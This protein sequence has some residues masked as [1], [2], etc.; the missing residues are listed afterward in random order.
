MAT[1]IQLIY[2]DIETGRIGRIAD[3]S[4]IITPAEM[5]VFTW[6]TVLFRNVPSHAILNPTS[7]ELTINGIFKRSVSELTDDSKMKI[8]FNSEIAHCLEQMSKLINNMRF[9]KTKNTF[10]HTKLIPM[11]EKEIEI[12][13]QT[14]VP[15]PLLLSLVDSLEDL[16]VAV[17]ELELSHIEYD[18]FLIATEATRN[19]WFRKISNSNNPQ[20]TLNSFFKSIG[21]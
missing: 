7:W 18:N 2:T 21:I 1:D 19:K 15:G 20:E 17:A 8:Q 14:Q 5:D 13:K 11:Y 12:Y 6:Q 4:P 10:A 16:P 3:Y 9:R